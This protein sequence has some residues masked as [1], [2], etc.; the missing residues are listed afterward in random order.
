MGIYRVYAGP[1]G[2]SHIEELDVALPVGSGV[3][4]VDSHY[5]LPYQVGQVEHAS[6][7]VVKRGSMEYKDARLPST[8]S[9]SQTN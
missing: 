1:D 4:S 8:G 6:S 7:P 2:E 9:S 5:S 3:D